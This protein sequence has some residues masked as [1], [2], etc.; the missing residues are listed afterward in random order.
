MLI[1]GLVCLHLHWLIWEWNWCQNSNQVLLHCREWGLHALWLQ[2]ALSVI[3]KCWQ[4]VQKPM[5]R[6]EMVSNNLFERRF[7]KKEKKKG[8]KIFF[9]D[10]RWWFKG[11]SVWSKDVWF[12]TTQKVCNYK[13]VIRPK[14]LLPL[15]RKFP[16]PLTYSC[17]VVSIAYPGLSP[18]IWRRT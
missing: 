12:S 2:M 18:W 11:R 5:A 15:H 14:F 8:K 9:K 1:F 3:S 13:W 6:V 7:S 10:A 16:L 4:P 17:L